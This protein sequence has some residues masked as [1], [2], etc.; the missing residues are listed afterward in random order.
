MQNSSLLAFHFEQPLSNRGPFL[1]LKLCFNLIKN[2]FWCVYKTLNMLDLAYNILTK[3]FFNF[4]NIYDCILRH[5]SH[6][7]F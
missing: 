5:Y 3:I 6:N 7:V 4:L 1:H 2:H